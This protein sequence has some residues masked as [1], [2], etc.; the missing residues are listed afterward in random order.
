MNY[1]VE[2]NHCHCHPETCC[3]NDYK[4]VD[5]DGEKVSTHFNREDAQSLAN[6]LNRKA[7]Q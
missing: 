4:V 1:R 5:A 6:L 2:I 7:E 3:C